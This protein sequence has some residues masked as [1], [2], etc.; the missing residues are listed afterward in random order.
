[1]RRFDARLD[2]HLSRITSQ[3][4]AWHAHQ[5]DAVREVELLGDSMIREM[6]RLQTQ[7][8]VLE[9]NLLEANRPNALAVES[10]ALQLAPA[11]PSSRAA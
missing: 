11:E 2:D 6:A 4:A 7:I 9:A 8:A 5:C 10:D 1:M 3:I